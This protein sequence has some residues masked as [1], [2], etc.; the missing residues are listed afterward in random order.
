M[1]HARKFT[2]EA[3]RTQREED[4][5]R[6]VG[7]SAYRRIGVSAYRRVG[8]WACGRV[9]VWA[10]GRVGDAVRRPGTVGRKTRRADGSVRASRQSAPVLSRGVGCD[11]AQENQTALNS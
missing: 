2:T 6:R 7:V 5:C 11:T 4:S 9:G 10:C 1:I 3:R 8:V